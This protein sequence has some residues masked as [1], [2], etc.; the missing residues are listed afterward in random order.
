MRKFIVI[1]LSLLALLFIAAV[2]GYKAGVRYERGRY[3]AVSD[4]V[5]T[6]K[7]IVQHEPKEEVRW[8]VRHDTIWAHAIDTLRVS[9]SVMV[10]LPIEQKMYADSNY[11]A[12]ISGYAPKLDSIFVKNR[13]YKIN[14]THLIKTKD[15]G[16]G[17]G[18]TVGPSVLY[19]GKVNI[20]LGASVGLTYKF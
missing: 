1:C 19:N 4:T 20:G 18:V 3:K 2:M 13:I 9:D 8:L 6:E 15:R 11:T 14:T 17:V 7:I 12:Y 5:Y 10:T 16:W